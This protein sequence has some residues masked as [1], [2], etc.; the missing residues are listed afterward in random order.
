MVTRQ[1]RFWNLHWTSIQPA[2]HPFG[3]RSEG[4]P[5]EGRI[6]DGWFAIA[7]N[8]ALQAAPA[9]LAAAG[10]RASRDNHHYRVIQ[11]LELT[12]G[13]ESKF[14]RSFDAFRK[15]RIVSNYEIG[16]GI[17]SPRS[18]RNDCYDRKN[19]KNRP[20]LRKFG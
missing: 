11:S 9:A 1:G 15:K 13:K 4:Q 2:A 12:I 3:T 6:D 16:G 18:P 5:G 20:Q 14:I 19:T 7:Y 10:Y 17:S 8:A